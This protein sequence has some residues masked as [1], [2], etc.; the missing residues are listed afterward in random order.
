LKKENI[1]P[2]MAG[3]RPSY[4]GLMTIPRFCYQR[5]LSRFINLVGI[6]SPGMTASPAI[7]QYVRKYFN[8][9]LRSMF[10]VAGIDR[11]L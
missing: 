3:I 5:R 2:D 11:K 1:H 9:F 4:R 7:A 10:H 6:E 8:Q